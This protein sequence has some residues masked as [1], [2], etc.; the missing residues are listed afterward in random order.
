MTDTKENTTIDL[1]SPELFESGTFKKALMRQIKATGGAKGALKGQDFIKRLTKSALEALLE[2]EMEE[3][4]GY[5]KYAE[6]G[7]NTGNSRNGKTSKKV[8]GDFGEINVD[9]PRDRNASFEP[10]LIKKRESNLGNFTDKIISLYARGL[11]TREIEEHLQEMYRLKFLLSLFHGPQ[12]V[13]KKNLS[14]GK[15]DLLTQYI[16]CFTSMD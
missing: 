14:S 16:Q 13:F 8:R 10:Q 11:S 12:N 9:T 6:E 1:T 5:P 4:V 2:V 15:I 7:K 3:H